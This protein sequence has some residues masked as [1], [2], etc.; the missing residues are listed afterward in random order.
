MKKII[1]IVFIALA[2]SACKKSSVT[3]ASLSAINTQ[4]IGTWVGSKNVSNY[5]D[6]GGKAQVYDNKIVYTYHINSDGTASKT[7][8]GFNGAI[9]QVYIKSV[10]YLIYSSNGLN[11]IN[12][13]VSP[14]DISDIYQIVSVTDHSLVLNINYGTPPGKLLIDVSPNTLG[15]NEVLDE[16]YTR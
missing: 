8:V 12:F 13:Q 5:I 7:V 4:I 14:G 11:Y 15:T 3:P 6:L 1:L 16:E 9:L 10:P 2:L